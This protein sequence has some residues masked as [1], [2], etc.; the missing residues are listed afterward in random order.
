MYSLHTQQQLASVEAV[1]FGPY[2][3]VT[4]LARQRP[5]SRQTLYRQAHALAHAADGAAH[6]LQLQQVRAELH[7]WQGQAEA[8]R[9]QLARTF[10][11]DADTQA[12]FAA[13]AQ[14]EGVSLPVARRLLQTLLKEQTPSVA[15]LGRYSRDAARRAAAALAVLDPL[16]RARVRDAALDELFAGRQ[17]ILMAVELDSLAWV[18]GQLSPTRDGAAWAAQLQRLPALELVTRDAGKGLDKGVALENT[19]RQECG[20][21]PVADQGD[22]FHLLRE[23]SGA[24]RRMRG[25]ATRALAAAEKADHERAQV[26][27]RGRDQSAV[28]RKA[29][30]A[31]RQGEAAFDA[32]SAAARAWERVRREALPLFTPTGQRNTRAQAEA[33]LAEALPALSGAD[34]DKVR[35]LL[36]RPGFFTFL[37]GAE[38]ALAALPVPADLV[39][40]AVL[41]EGARRRPEA[42]EGEGVSAAARCGVLLVAAVL[43]SVAGEAGS[44][45]VSLVRGVL[46]RAWRASSAVEGLNSVVRMHQGRH[47]RLTQSLLDLKRLYWNCRAFRTGKRK[48]QTPYGRLGLQ[49]PTTDWWLLLKIPPSE[50]QQ[51][52]SAQ[53]HVA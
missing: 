6:Q 50:L 39:E 16:C 29:Y 3:A 44:A 48:Q 52:L 34:W 7:Y 51:Q 18:T 27:K 38:R 31:W 23:G 4:Q 2:G 21:R 40:A 33:V 5:C 37:D 47:R 49:L 25:R 20:Q 45:A 32:W 15:Q 53:K 26:A 46:R 36:K 42:N 10:L 24:L 41:V 43:L 30:Q 22:H 13:L 12:Q 28:A 8:L 11:L 17:P 14:A 19:R 1:F 35:R 9:R